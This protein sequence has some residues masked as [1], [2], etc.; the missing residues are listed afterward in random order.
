M[1]SGLRMGIGADEVGSALKLELMPLIAGDERVASVVD[2]SVDGDDRPYPV[3]ALR[4]AQAVADGEIDR[5]ILIC[6]TGIGMCIAA[7]KV[8]GIRAAVVHDS[9]SAERSV[10]S[11]NCQVMCIGA[12]IVAPVYAARLVRE[13]L[14]YSFNEASA[15]AR[16]IAVIDDYEAQLLTGRRARS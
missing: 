1:T 12:R 3:V 9:Y 14:G 4:A 11:N 6:G 8:P 10:L 2:Y 13:W 15:S 5:A 16:K 7:G